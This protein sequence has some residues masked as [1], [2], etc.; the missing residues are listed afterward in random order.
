MRKIMILLLLLTALPTPTQAVVEENVRFIIANVSPTSVVPGYEGALNITVKNVGFGEGYRI[1][2]EVAPDAGS[3]I[4]F[5]GETKK[6]LEFYGQPCSDPVICNVLNAGDLATF[7]YKISVSDDAATGTYYIPLTIYW[8]YTGVE[9]SSTLNFGVEV[10]GEP[11]LVIASTSTSPSIV[12]PD[13]DFSLSLTVENIGTEAAKSAGLVLEL[14]RG[15]SGKATALLGTIDK[16][17]S[18]TATLHLRAEKTVELGSH[19][20]SAHLTYRDAGGKVY[21]DSLPLELFIQ[22]RGEAKLSIAGV[23]TTPSKIYPNTDFTLTMLVENTGKQAAKAARLALKLPEGFTG[24]STAFLGTIEEGGSASASL[25]M[26]ALKNSTP[27]RYPA[28]A[29][30]GFVDEQG[31]SEE[32]RLPFNLFILDRGEVLLE[33]SGKSTSPA[34]PRPGEDFT[35]TVQLENIGEQDAKSV[36]IALEPVPELM[37]EMVSFVGEIEKDDVSTGVFDLTVSPQAL[38]GSK[39]IRARIT[40][41]DERGVTKELTREFQIFINERKS[42]SRNRAMALAGIGALLIIYLWRRGKSEYSEA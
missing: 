4:A 17:S 20:L 24:E 15:F 39:K 38:P 3:P 29:L 5:I 25:D 8:L 37:G 31:R 13:T 14:D 12:Y 19:N 23:N 27:G 41:I 2:A 35:L 36:Q 30:I 42:S 21:R 11:K 7:T 6:Y 18:A 26:K 9:K 33:I 34:K 10:K 16:D 28:E 22:D 32:V 40:Y 1:N